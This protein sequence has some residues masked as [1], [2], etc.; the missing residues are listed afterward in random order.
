MIQIL[1]IDT[2]TE[3]CSAALLMG[4]TS[5]SR[6]EVAPQGH[7]RLILPMVESLLAEA[8]VS[9]A[10]LDAIAFGRG[11]G[12]FTGVRI[13]VGI[14]Q[15]L[16]LGADKPLLGISNLAVLAQRCALDS[17][18]EQVLCAIDARMGEVYF[19]AYRRQG[20][21]MVLQ[22]DEA[23]LP[24]EA[25]LEQGLAALAEYPGGWLGAGTGW[26]A[27]AEALHP[28]RSQLSGLGVELPDAEAMLP[29]AQLAWQQGLA[30]EAALAQPV[31]LRDKVTWKK[32]PGRE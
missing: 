11:P 6:Y 24:P 21:V 8:G 19:G 23:V 15:G 5:L 25:A 26:A 27:Y 30:C 17:Q 22:G 2:A 28:L 4:Q 20:A 32:L 14:A 7:T 16:A 3:A 31:Y 9:L 13:G 12:S 1:A 10:Q 18:A 29:L